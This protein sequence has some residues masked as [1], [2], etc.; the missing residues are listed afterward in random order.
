[1]KGQNGTGETVAKAYN[2]IRHRI[3]AM[4]MKPG[5]VISE[6]KLSEDVGVSRTPLREALK[7]LEADGLI[8]S[9]GRRKRVF[10]LTIHE[11]EEIFELKIAIESAVARLATEKGQQQDFDTLRE[12]LAQMQ[13]FAEVVPEDTSEAHDRWLNEWLDMDRRF[14]DLLFA[15]AGNGRAEQIISNLN[16]LWHRLRVGLLAMEGRLQKSVN[17]HTGIARAI[18][19]GKPDEAEV[20][21]RDHLNN[22][23][24][25]IT[26]IMS[27][28]HFPT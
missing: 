16:D 21:M 5:E 11:I 2:A 7:Q 13:R 17:E 3:L 9:S 15:M 4:E 12:I 22:L 20:R 19:D 8:V 10:V 23:K 26:T 27:A 14:H 28:F 25:M 24:K 6:I 1:M 18:L